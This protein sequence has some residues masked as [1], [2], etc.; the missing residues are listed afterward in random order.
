METISILPIVVLS[1]IAI[2]KITDFESAKSISGVAIK[3]SLISWAASEESKFNCPVVSFWIIA[4]IEERSSLFSLRIST[5]PGVGVPLK[6][7]K[8][9]KTSY[10][11]NE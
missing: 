10:C 7:T 6:Y 8:S 4:L 3:K 9:F 5:K 11:I 2:V 1:I